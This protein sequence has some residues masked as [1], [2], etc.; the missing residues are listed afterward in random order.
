MMTPTPRPRR[1]PR[2]QPP[3]R[4]PPPRRGSGADPRSGLIDADGG[5]GRAH[6]YT[7]AHS[8]AA[9]LRTD[10]Y[11][12]RGCGVDHA[13]QL[14]AQQDP[15]ARQ[16]QHHFLGSRRGAGS[17]RLC[18]ASANWRVERHR[19]CSHLG[20]RLR[21]FEDHVFQIREGV[22]F[23][24]DWGELTAHDVA[25]S[26]NETQADGSTWARVEIGDFMSEGVALDDRTFEFRFK[27]GAACGTGGCTRT[28]APY[29]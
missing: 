2:P 27:S 12:E 24:D 6:I 16:S 14:L 21:S 10:R 13:T 29:R 26:F 4:P 3:P 9:S 7:G 22:D 8:H 20:N 5:P 28:L 18:E 25:H 23:H 19:H 1:Q 15:V 11:A 17:H